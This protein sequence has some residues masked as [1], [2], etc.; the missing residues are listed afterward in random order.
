[1]AAFLGVLLSVQ[2]N[3]FDGA[4]QA[5]MAFVHGL[6]SD[7]LTPV[8]TFLSWFGDAMMNIVL[9][10]VALAVLYMVFKQRSEL[11]LFVA[12]VGG[13]VILNT[14]LKHIIMR[15]RPL[16][17]AIAMEDGFAFPSGHS[18][19]AVA[20]YGTLTYLLWKHVPARAGRVLMLLVSLLM[21]EG[22]GWSRVYLGVHYPSDVIGGYLMSA[23]WLLAV[24]G[25][26]ETYRKRKHPAGIPQFKEAANER[27]KA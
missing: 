2:G 18:M 19:A 22:I 16:E 5:M 11:V 21:I 4:D 8:A 27:I 6:R 15:A 17:S 13:S 9:A 12:A 24:I 7:G 10:V 14:V 23:A 26:Y 25:I 20:L 3:G 1:M